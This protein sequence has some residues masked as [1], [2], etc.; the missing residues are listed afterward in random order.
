MHT[1]IGIVPNF[2]VACVLAQIGGQIRTIPS[3][4]GSRPS[5]SARSVAFVPSGNATS[6]AAP[7]V[8][9]RAT[10]RGRRRDHEDEPLGPDV[11]LL[12]MR[13]TDLRLKVGEPCYELDHAANAGTDQ[14]G[15]G[16]SKV[17]AVWHGCLEPDL[18]RPG[19]PWPQA[20][21]ECK[22][23]PVE[24]S[25]DPRKE[26]DPWLQ[27]ND[28]GME[29]EMAQPE[30]ADQPALDP[31]H[32]RYRSPER[33]SHLG[34][35]HAGDE[36]GDTQLAADIVQQPIAESP[37]V[38]NEGLSVRHARIMGT[39]PYQRLTPR[40]WRFAAA[41]NQLR[42]SAPVS[43]IRDVKLRPGATFDPELAQGLS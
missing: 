15:I 31:A 26:R 41:R 24:R 21:E 9:E 5:S 40:L 33:Q 22:L 37:G 23:R 42:S 8:P 17:A 7:N 29:A 13:R 3:A 30:A 36:S 4:P 43:P 12:A 38:A 20:F 25:C 35:G 19:D 10:V 6:T 28:G 32:V 16:C 34:L 1:L 14:Q 27:P 11:S 39:P 2:S 18:P